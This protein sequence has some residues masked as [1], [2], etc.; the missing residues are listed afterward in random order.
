MLGKLQDQRE[1][2]IVKRGCSEEGDTCIDEDIKKV[3]PNVTFELIKGVSE[4]EDEVNSNHETIYEEEV[5]ALVQL[6]T[7]LAAGENVYL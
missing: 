1:K 5:D 2:A 4:D 3:L 6:V 7:H